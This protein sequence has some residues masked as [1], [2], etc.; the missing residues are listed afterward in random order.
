MKKLIMSAAIV[1]AAAMAQAA[2]VSW[3]SSNLYDNDG[4]ALKGSPAA[5]AYVFLLSQSEYNALTDIWGTY[6]DSALAAAD[7]SNK[8]STTSY[9]QKITVKS[10]NTATANTTYYA[11][12]I[13]LYTKDDVTYYLAEKGSATT[14]DDG[15]ASPLFAQSAS[16]SDGAKGAWTAVGG[17]TPTPGG[18]PE[19]TSG[20]L[21]LLGIAGLALRRRRA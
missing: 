18:V 20:L 12:I 3:K 21:V 4:A 13:T 9:S 6:G 2:A 19:P 15:N 5:T 11:A 8:G 10:P 7:Y 1:C 17:D 16:T 14:G